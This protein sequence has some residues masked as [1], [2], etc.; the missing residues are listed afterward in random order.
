MTELYADPRTPY[1]EVESITAFG[2]D[3]IK[4]V[5]K[6]SFQDAKDLVTQLVHETPHELDNRQWAE[7]IDLA[8]EII[9]QNFL[10]IADGTCMSCQS[11]SGWSDEKCAHCRVYQDVRKSR[12]VKPSQLFDIRMFPG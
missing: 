5:V 11:G 8:N 2:P 3:E 10:N 12:V 9:I 4:G 1:S 7:L 6:V